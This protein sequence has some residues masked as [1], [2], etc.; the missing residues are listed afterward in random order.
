MAPLA[1][2]DREARNQQNHYRQSDQADQNHKE[3]KRVHLRRDLRRL[4]REEREVRQPLD[5]KLPEYW[6]D[7]V[8]SLSVHLCSCPCLIVLPGIFAEHRQHEST[9]RKH[10]Y[11]PA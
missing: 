3:V 1:V 6:T 9:Q 10:G 4:R 7:M 8:H 2:E 11:E 5:E